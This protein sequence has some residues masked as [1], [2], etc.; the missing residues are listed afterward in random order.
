MTKSWFKSLSVN[1][2]RTYL[3]LAVALVVLI[4][5]GSFLWQHRASA[6]VRQHME[7]GVRYWQ[8]GQNAEAA[9]EWQKVVELDPGHM[10]AWRLLGDYYL[11]AKQP[12]QALKAL[13]NAAKNDSAPIE[14]QVNIARCA[15][16]LKDFAGA[17]FHIQTALRG[18]PDNIAALN[19][20]ITIARESENREEYFKYVKHLAELQPQDEATL[21]LLANEYTYRHE[22]DQVLPLAERI[23]RL[24]NVSTEA[25]FLRALSLFEKDPKPENLQRAEAD[26]QRILELDPQDVEAHRYLGRIYMR[27][28]QPQKAVAHF[29]AIGRGR[30]F[31]SA[32]FLELSNAYRRVGNQQKSDLLRRRFFTLKELNAQMTG[33]KDRINRDPQDAANYLNMVFLLLNN[34]TNSEDSFLLYRYRFQERNLFSVDHYLQRAITLSPQENKVKE[35]AQ[36][37]KKAFEGYFQAGI[38][39]LERRDLT[40]ARAYLMRAETLRP[41]DAKLQKA[42]HTAGLLPVENS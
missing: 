6:P 10:E 34:V 23:L 31:A 36:K 13:Q 32:H 40:Q 21:I 2:R 5:W 16:L 28:N 18:D 1:S 37:L 3:S 20:A 27:M 29:E 15:R 25:L 7:A 8:N 22:Y 12:E 35:A 26:L 19:E 14:L 17:Q 24:N 9:S 41:S 4:V 11:A 38:K 42:L 39:A 33:S 30:P